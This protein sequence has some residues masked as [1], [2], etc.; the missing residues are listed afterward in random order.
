MVNFQFIVCVIRFHVDR[1]KIVYMDNK[2][3]KKMFKILV[4]VFAQIHVI[5]SNVQYVTCLLRS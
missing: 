1:L 3:K 5:C 4:G 2:T